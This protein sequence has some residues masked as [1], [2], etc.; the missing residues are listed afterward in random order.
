MT[1]T[2]RSGFVVLQDKTAKTDNREGND[3]CSCVVWEIWNR[4]DG[5][6]YTMCDGY[7]DFLRRASRV[8]RSLHRPFLAVVCRDAQ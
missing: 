2:S 3:G 7:T 6:V 5:L 1:V 4:K 8:A